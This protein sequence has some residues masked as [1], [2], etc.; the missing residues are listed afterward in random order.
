MYG[1]DCALWPSCW[2]GLA[3]GAGNSCVW[4]SHVAQPSQAS[5]PSLGSR[6][7]GPINAPFEA[8]TGEL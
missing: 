7:R 4:G 5:P 1:W 6:D 8:H 2:E 3:R